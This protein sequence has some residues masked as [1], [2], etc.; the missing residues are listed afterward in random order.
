MYFMRKVKCRWR[1]CPRTLEDSEFKVDKEDAVKDGVK[2]Y[3]KDC[4][5]KFKQYMQILEIYEKHVSNKENWQIIQKT[6]TN[7]I[8]KFGVEYILF[9]LCKS[10]K[11]KEIYSYDYR[12]FLDIHK[13][14]IANKYKYMYQEYKQGNETRQYGK[15]VSLTTKQYNEL[16]E[17]YDV[18]KIKRYIDKINNY[19]E[20]SGKKYNNYYIT[21]L[22]WIKRDQG[23]YM[24]LHG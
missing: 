17:K 20:Q 11:N 22:D 18:N 14:L 3:C 13:F 23:K 1:F 12:G 15:Y 24:T 6:L 9:V 16:I 7:W 10:I 2:Y 8:P 19:C 5:D 4:Y 21:I